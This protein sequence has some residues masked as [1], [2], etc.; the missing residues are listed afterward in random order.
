MVHIIHKKIPIVLH[1]FP[2]YFMNQKLEFLEICPYVRKIIVRN[3]YI[4]R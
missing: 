3:L 1:Y 2:F 4:K